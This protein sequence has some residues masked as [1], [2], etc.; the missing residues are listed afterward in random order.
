MKLY[1]L[2]FSEQRSVKFKRH[3]IFWLAWFLY[4]TVTYLV[5][6]NW[7]PAWNIFGPMPQIDKYGFAW[8]SLRIFI[9]ASLHVLVHMGMIYSILYFVL[10]RYFNKNSNPLSTTAIL[11]I[12]I[13]FFAFINYFNFVL[14][15]YLSTKMQYFQKMPGMEFTIPIWSRQ[16]LFNYPTIIGFAIGIKLLKKWYLKQKE[17]LL[18]EKE[19]VNIELELLKSQVHPHFLFNTL[20]NIYS[21]IINDSP[22]APEV[23]KKLSDLLRYLI[24]DCSHS[25]V[26]L[27]SELQMIEDYIDLEKIRYGKS[28][29]MQLEVK[30]KAENKMI[31]PLL[32]IPFLENSFKHGASQMLSHPWINLDLTIYDDELLLRLSNSKP[33]LVTESITSKGLGL[34]N[35][36]KRLKLLYPD[37]HLLSISQDML[38]YNVELRIP[39]ENTEPIIKLSENKTKVYELV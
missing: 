31:S 7:I 1:D 25:L 35:V 12:V 15:F 26:K 16:V 10:P 37:N 18:I 11:L 19:K 38:S 34:S 23:L 2:V 13:A 14:S 36:Q 20:N 30:G 32:I 9:S 5:P 3:L 29:N 17:T 8:A 6:T 24:Y 33:V 4:L 21:F 39:I 22:K 27:Q 28:F